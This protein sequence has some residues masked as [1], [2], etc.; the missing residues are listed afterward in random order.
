MQILPD[1]RK[2]KSQNEFIAID[3]EAID[4]RYALLSSSKGPSLFRRKGLAT[5]EIFRFL[6]RLKRENP[7]AFF[8]GFG[9]TYDVNHFMRDIDD[10]TLKEILFTED[11]DFVEWNGWKI[12]YFP[13]KVF[14]LRDSDGTE[15]VWFDTL[16]FFGVSF[17]EVLRRILGESHSEIDAGKQKRGTFTYRDLASIR[18]YNEKECALLVRVME[19]L[20]GLFQEQGIFLGRFHGP[21]AVADFLLGNRGFAIHKDYPD[22]KQEEV[23]ISLW[24]A[25]DCA[26]FGGRIENLIVGSVKNVYSYDLNSAYPKAATTLRKMRYTSEW[27]WRK[28]AAEIRE[29]AVY[30]VEWSV[31]KECPIGPFPWR[32]KGGKIFFP[33]E[34]IS[35]IWGEELEAGIKSFPGKIKILESWSQPRQEL[36]RLASVIPTIYEERNALKAKGSL[37]EYTLK[38]ALNSMYGKFAQRIGRSS[39]RCLPWAGQITAWTRAR[40]LDAVR[41]KEKD[42]LAFATD[43]IFSRK[44]LRLRQSGALG[45]WKEE[46]FDSLLVIMNGFYHL[47]GKAVKKS[48]TR[49]I[50]KAALIPWE[51]IIQTLNTHQR[52]ISTMPTFVT[53]TMALHFPKAFG[54]T[55][56]TF[57]NRRKEIDPFS[58][59]KRH[60]ARETLRNW[61][62]D[63]SESNTVSFGKKLSYP[64]SLTL[65]PSFILEKQK[66]LCEEEMSDE[67]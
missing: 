67:N 18:S 6:M 31:S 8:V 28:G 40:L 63:F 55:R 61:A 32:D 42:I 5:E 56:L 57:V 19:K 26:Y 27:E 12:L 37:G 54:K 50:G 47:D 39:Y 20:D 65:T 21:G 60:F 62:T 25:W 7:S 29:D 34:G 23:P 13:K 16:S 43:G 9:T 30:K 1:R 11:K 59:A 38:I 49:G 46:R 15:F 52:I 22:Y 66:E 48:A 45:D 14:R 10:G 3:G 53:H 24:N 36:S 2:A 17:V 58:C 4:E 33:R 64:S 51:E 41:G 35:W 44:P